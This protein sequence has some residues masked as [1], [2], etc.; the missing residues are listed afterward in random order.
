MSS[1]GSMSTRAARSTPS[2]GGTR[3]PVV[4]SDRGCERTQHVV[5]DRGRAVAATKVVFAEPADPAAGALVDVGGA[6]CVD[7]RTRPAVNVAAEVR[8]QVVAGSHAG[9]VATGERPTLR[10][11][12]REC[13]LA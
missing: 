3:K 10:T 2:P 9:H 12:R 7:L 8:L 13:T 11:A 4:R 1:S 5:H 6:P